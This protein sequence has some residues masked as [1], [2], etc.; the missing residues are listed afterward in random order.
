RSLALPGGDPHYLVMT[1]TPIPR[2][3]A[4]AVYGDLDVSTIRRPPPGRQPVT[5]R[6]VSERDRAWVLGKLRE[7]LEAGRQ[8][9]VVC[10]L[11]ED[12]EHLD[13][14]S[15]TSTLTEIQGA[16]PDRRVELM[17]GRQDEGTRSAVMDRFRRGE[18]DVLVCTTVVEVGVDVPNATYLVIE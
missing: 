5:T 13:A 3:V 15:T 6:W 7:G 1:A 9:F 4:L 12:S 10:P 14:R 8:V 2:T 18:T 16:L 17:H 11:V